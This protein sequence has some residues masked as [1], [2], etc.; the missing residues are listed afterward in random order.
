M[1]HHDEVEATSIG[2]S[3]LWKHQEVVCPP[4]VMMRNV[5]E[6]CVTIQKSARTQSNIATSYV[7]RTDTKWIVDQSA[8][9][10]AHLIHERTPMAFTI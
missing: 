5:S 3:N 1:L 9:F 4:K 7:G 10:E 6:D 8:F 2:Q